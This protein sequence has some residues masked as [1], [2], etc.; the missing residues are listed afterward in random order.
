MKL[1]GRNAIITG[2]NQGF[3]LA[4]AKAFIK[5]GASVAICAR[6]GKKLTETQR[7]LTLAASAGQKVIAM[8]C[9]VSSEPDV[10][11]FIDGTIGKLRKIDVLVNNAG[12]YGPMGAIETIGSAQWLDAVAVNLFGVFFT[13]KRIIPHMKAAGYGKIINL[14]GGGATAP[15]PRVSAYAASKAAVV[16]LTETLAEE[17][18]GLNIDINAVAPGALNT[19][20]LDEV[21]KAG[22]GKVGK[23]FYEK[24]L[25]QK[26][27][28]GTPP[29]RGAALCVYLASPASNGITGKLISAVWDPWERFA[30]YK[31]DLRAS[32]IYTLRRIVAEDRG[33]KWG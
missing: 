1:L 21:L 8:R 10:A 17:C 29:E 32:D 14:S 31:E 15:L 12:V 3:G 16:R 33:R 25:R 5:E 13:C 24:A 30:E 19:R 27:E 23:G 7:A 18:R 22:E 4:V 11:A 28:G 9:D 26:E 6:D 20:L 2:A